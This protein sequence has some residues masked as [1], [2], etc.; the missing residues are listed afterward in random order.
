MRLDTPKVVLLTSYFEDFSK[1]VIATDEFDVI[2]F[3]KSYKVS[4]AEPLYDERR[5]F[6][7]G[8]KMDRLLSFSINQ[9]SGV[10]HS[11]Q[12]VCFKGQEAHALTVLKR[13]LNKKY[14]LVIKG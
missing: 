8:I 4:V 7:Q 2:R 11:Y 6:P 9:T 14:R 13:F 1:V 12:V 10:D 5:E 3:T